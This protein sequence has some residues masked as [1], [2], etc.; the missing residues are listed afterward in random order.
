MNNILLSAQAFSC[1][2]PSEGALVYEL[3]LILEDAV[4]WE[5]K[6]LRWVWAFMGSQA[7]TREAGP[8]QTSLSKRCTSESLS[9]FQAF[10]NFFDCMLEVLKIFLVSNLNGTS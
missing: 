7:H 3:L 1:K 8:Q 2:R 5:R 4:D 10:S 9:S 6:K